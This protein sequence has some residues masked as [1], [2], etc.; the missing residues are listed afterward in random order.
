MKTGAQFYTIR[1][2][3]KT[4]EGLYESLKRVADIGYTTVQLSGVCQYDPTEMKAA[5]KVFY[6]TLYA[7]DPTSVGG[8]LPSDAFYYGAG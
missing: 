7:I 8:N 6:E 5:L 3:C 1:D 2:F 4:P